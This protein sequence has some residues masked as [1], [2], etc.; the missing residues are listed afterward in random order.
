MPS[1]TD[2]HWAP[3]KDYV[4]GLLERKKTAKQILVLLKNK[5][6]FEAE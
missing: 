1:T 2:E 4:E 3:Y 6:G 5:K